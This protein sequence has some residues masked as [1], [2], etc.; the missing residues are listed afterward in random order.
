MKNAKPI[1]IWISLGI[2]GLSCLYL[3]AVLGFWF[4]VKG[5]AY[6]GVTV[7]GISVSGKTKSEISEMLTEKTNI[8]LKVKINFSAEKSTLATPE[9]TGVGFDIAKTAENAISAGNSNPFL[10]GF[11]R[12]IP[13][14][15][16]FDQDK[17]SKKMTE[18]ARSVMTPVVNSKVT[19]KDTK[20]VVEDGTPGKRL[21]YFETMA[22]I[23]DAAG[24]LEG[25]VEI[26]TFV[27]PPTFTSTDLTEEAALLISSS[28]LPLNLFDGPTKYVVTP[29]TI[30]TWVE[31][32]RPK[33]VLARTFEADPLLDPL[34]SGSSNS[35][36]SSSLVSNYLYDLSKKI[37]TTPVNAQ[38]NISG[39][40]ATVFVPSRDGKTL[41][42]EKST[43]DILLALEE[44]RTDVKL[45]VDITKPEI[46]EGSLNYLGI[47]EL[48]STGSSN[49][50]GSPTNRRHNIKVGAARFNGVLI[51][52]DQTFSFNTALGPVDASTGYLPELVIKDNKTIPEYGGGMCQVSSTAFRAALNAGL[53]I[54]ERTAHSYPVSYYKPYGV[55]ATVYLPKPDLVFK[56]DTGKY[57]LVQTRIV[58]NNLYFD[59]YGT[60][61]QR[62]IKFG[63]NVNQSG[64]VFPVESVTPYIFDQGA[65]GNNSFTAIIYRFIYDMSGNLL[66]TDKFTSKYDTPDN[67]PH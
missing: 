30:V 19:K 18:L 61:P 57:I 46:N 60:K 5:K 8:W 63:G 43:A 54:I 15:V 9:E 47:V 41:N 67:Y 34:F 6:P 26:A 31:L 27:V 17:V 48:L 66:K 22:R 56:N 45:T 10:L 58:G 21:N 40:K 62:T 33:R 4:S 35:I 49:F 29:E 59:F 13:I 51:K 32:G 44:K 53:P 37:N 55:D 38:L 3:I 36:F 16:T 20:L 12:D 23:R 7:A 24:N 14:E 11:K 42:T 50:A 39:A 25:R 2:V 52:P 1:V 64:A 65:R 28:A